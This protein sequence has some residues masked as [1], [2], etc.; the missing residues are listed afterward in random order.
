MPKIWQQRHSQKQKLKKTGKRSHQPT[1][2]G[3]LARWSS[4]RKVVGGYRPA[5]ISCC[6]AQTNKSTGTKMRSKAKIRKQ[7]LALTSHRHT[8]TYERR[9]PF[10]LKRRPLTWRYWRAL[11]TVQSRKKKQQQFVWKTSKQWQIKRVPTHYGR[12]YR[13][14][15]INTQWRIISKTKQAKKKWQR[16]FQLI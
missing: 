13:H 11:Y 2:V 16:Q 5:A 10:C 6:G 12:S 7:M 14:N 4:G 9:R 3:W 15:N 8:P 1:L